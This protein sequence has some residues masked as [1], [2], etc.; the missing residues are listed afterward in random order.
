M[1]MYFGAAAL[2]AY[3]AARGYERLLLGSLSQAEALEQAR[4]ELSVQVEA[5][6]RDI[7]AALTEL[8][9]RTETIRQMSVPVVPL[10]NGVVVLP[11]VGSL[12]EQRAQLLQE[13]L[14]A[15]VYRDHCRVV[16]IEITGVPRV[17]EAMAT[18]L[19]QTAQAVRL[20]GAEVVLVGVRAEV[21][22]T[23]VQ[24]GLDLGRL[25][26][27]RDLAGGLHYALDRRLDQVIGD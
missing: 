3:L 24:L 17:D 11:L 25:V 4:A 6:T 14:L 26:V 18:A 22:Q 10:A 15:A 1:A 21:A 5:Q 2:L 9:Q 8:E 23:I 16:L 13:Q 27:R 12:D 20:L 7:R 19:L